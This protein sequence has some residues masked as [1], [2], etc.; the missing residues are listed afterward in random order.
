MVPSQETG[1]QETEDFQ[2]LIW[3]TL[4][5]ILKNHPVVQ[6]QVLPETGSEISSVYSDLQSTQAF[7]LV[8]KLKSVPTGFTLGVEAELEKVFSICPKLLI[9]AELYGLVLAP[10]LK[11]EVSLNLGGQFA[12]LGANVS[13]FI[14]ILTSMF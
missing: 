2:D 7:L 13:A 8:Q 4:D 3:K 10:R 14:N 11:K 6:G 5:L 12:T 1:F 9:N